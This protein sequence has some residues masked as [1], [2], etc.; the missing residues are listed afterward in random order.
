[1][2]LKNNQTKIKQSN[3]IVDAT[4]LIVQ[5]ILATWALGSFENNQKNQTNQ[6]WLGR[7]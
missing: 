2:G 5:L 6:T 3:P 4:P 1:M 7:W